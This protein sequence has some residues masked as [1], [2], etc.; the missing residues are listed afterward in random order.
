MQPDEFIQMTHIVRANSIEH[1]EIL[2]VKF[3]TIH[4]LVDL[5]ENY[6]PIYQG[7]VE[8]Q[9]LEHYCDVIQEDIKYIT[10]TIIREK[11]SK[12]ES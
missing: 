4:K 11:M 10:Q 9:R 5:L 7:S 1:G 3:E 2:R 6:K 8:K 12:N